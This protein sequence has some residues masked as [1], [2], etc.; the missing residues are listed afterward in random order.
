MPLNIFIVEDHPIMRAVLTEIF[1][2]EPGFTVCGWA[3]SGEDA[4][5]LLAEVAADVVLVDVSLPEMNG[6]DLIHALME[7]SPGL[8]CLVLSGHG[9]TSYIQRALDAGARGYV[10]KGDPYELPGAI[11]QVAHGDRYFS[12][13]I[14]HKVPGP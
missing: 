10:L 2:D 1:R 4:V 7:Q 9:E 5:D 11:Q 8:R 3:T 14:R 13:P 6:I 12:E